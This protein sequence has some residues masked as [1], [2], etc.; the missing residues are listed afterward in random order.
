MDMAG[1]FT[2]P[3]P[4]SYSDKDFLV[5]HENRQGQNWEHG[6]KPTKLRLLL[7]DKE[8]KTIYCEKDSL[9]DQGM[10]KLGIHLRETEIRFVSFTLPQ[11]QFE[12]D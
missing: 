1:R 12:M 3:L 4:P 6:N 11:N 8:G 10:T 2:T 9:F 5:L 7:F